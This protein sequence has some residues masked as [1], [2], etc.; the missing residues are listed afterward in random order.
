L[1]STADIKIL[2]GLQY[3]SP[4]RARGQSHDTRKSDVWSLG[5]T[6]FEILVG[7]TPFEK[8]E[9]ESFSSKEEL[10]QYWTRTVKGKWLGEWTFSRPL[11][12]L[13]KK[14]LSPNADIRYTAR[15]AFHDPY[16]IEGNVLTCAVLC[17]TN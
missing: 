2:Y 11:E 9:G 6:L 17:L 12:K 8:Y 10:E 1:L 16:F 4:E 13:L 5:I 7:R 14:M 3:L 15:E